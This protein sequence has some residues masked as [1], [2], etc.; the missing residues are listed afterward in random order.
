MKIAIVTSEFEGLTTNAGIGTAYRN[1]GELLLAHGHEVTV[2]FMPIELRAGETPKNHARLLARWKARRARMTALGFSVVI[3][4]PDAILG[5]RGNAGYFLGRSHLV[6]HFLRSR[7]FD[8]VHAPDN[9][10]L[11]YMCLQARKLGAE[12]QDTR[13]VIGAHGPRIWVDELNRCVS[14]TSVLASQ[15]DRCS[16][17]MADQLVSPSRYMLD[18]LRSRGWTLP[19]DSRIIPNVNRLGSRFPAIPRGSLELPTVVFF[20][21][22]E[23]RKGVD[24]FAEA[25]LRLLRRRPGLGTKSPLKLIFLGRDPDPARSATTRLSELFAP[26]GERIE[27]RFHGGLSSEKSLAL[28]RSLPGA[29]VCMPSLCDNSPYV[30][31]EAIEA[32]LN[33]VAT[34]SG[35]QAELVHPDDRGK[36]L[37]NPDVSSLSLMIER[38]LDRPPLRVRP[39]SSAL[40]ANPKWLEFHR[41]KRGSRPHRLRPFSSEPAVSIV[42]HNRSGRLLSSLASALSQNYGNLEICIPRTARLHLPARA[43]HI[44]LREYDPRR[45]GTPWHSAA[46]AAQGKYVLFLQAPFASRSS[47]S[48]WVRSAETFAQAD[49]AHVV[50]CGVH[51]RQGFAVDPF[52]LWDRHW[53]LNACL[54]PAGVSFANERAIMRLYSTVLL[55]GKKIGLF[56]QVVYR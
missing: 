23:A 38:R 39:S 34:R 19:S 47:V 51:S 17:E 50:T 37:C 15:F 55:Q 27:I 5:Y 41:A 35:G 44:R 21:R 4:A 29:V 1:L 54:R 52:A 28:L 46:S 9:G 7:R 36:A 22:L 11:L 56:P 10:G 6:Y 43:S 48:E 8:L 53:L 32:G 14:E 42:L 20:G 40:A 33:M 30:L 18:H 45:L 3:P 31:V 24:L 2:V 25:V 16:I 13:F 26:F 49:P 12:F